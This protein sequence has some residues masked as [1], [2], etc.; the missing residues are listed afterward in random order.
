M[1]F[2]KKTIRFV[3]RGEYITELARSWFYQEGRGYE[4]CMELLLDSMCGTDQSDAE[5][6]RLAEDVLLGRA[7]LGGNTGDGSYH[8]EIYEPDE[9]PDSEF[10]VWK[11]IDKLTQKI[12][13]MRKEYDE[14]GD[15]YLR[16]Y[17]F[18]PERKQIYV[19]TGTTGSRYG[20]GFADSLLDSFMKRHLSDSTDD[21]GWLEPSGKFHP[22]EWG[23]HQEWAGKWMQEHLTEEEWLEDTTNYA[24]DYLTERGWVLLHNPSQGI[25]I[26][27][28]KETHRY[29]KAQ[30]DFLYDY[31][32]NRD[33]EKEAN[34]VFQEE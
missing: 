1:S 23:E 24:G 21:Y 7:A 10:S 27:T 13:K 20:S 15:R 26:P 3:V 29:T 6:R 33:C 4:K 19:E 8:L 12:A 14:L 2:E 34:A 28:R 9:E 16:A 25:A 18:V 31:F 30:K 22:V 17:E 5:L 11:E 32:I